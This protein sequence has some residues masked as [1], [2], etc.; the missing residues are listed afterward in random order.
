MLSLIAPPGTEGV[1][2]MLL[3]LFRPAAPVL[4]T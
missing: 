2:W 1:L 3:K 4:S